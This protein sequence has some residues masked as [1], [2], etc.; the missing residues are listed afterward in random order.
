[1]QGEADLLGEGARLLQGVHD[2]RRAGT[3]SPS[4][5]HQVA[6]QLPVLRLLDR[7]QRRAEQAHPV[8]VEHAGRRP[9]PWPG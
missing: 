2:G 6:E 4:C 9:G 5:Q 7:L 8:A 3:G 1:M